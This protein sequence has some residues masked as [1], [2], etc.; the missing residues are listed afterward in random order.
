MSSDQTLERVGT[1]ASERSVKLW[2]TL[3]GAVVN[4]ALA[5]G[6]VTFGFIGHSQALLVDG[7]H[8]LS[9]LVSDFLVVVAAHSSGKE[10]DEDHPYGHARFETAGTVAIGVL[11][12]MLAGG[13]AYDAAQRLIEQER[14]WTPHWIAL[15]AAVVSVAAKEAVYRYTVR[16]GREVGSSL[17]QANA[18]HHRSDALSSL[19]VIGAWFGTVAGYAWVDA[20]AAILVAAMVGAMGWQ[21]AWNAMRELVDTGLEPER[22]RELASVV[23]SV[24]GV[25]ADQGLR[26]RFMAGEVMIDAHIQVDPRLTVSEARRIGEAVRRRLKREC[27]EAGEVVVHIDVDSHS[28]PTGRRPPLR[29]RLLDDLS[30]AWRGQPEAE[31]ATDLTLHYEGDWVDVD[32]ELPADQVPPGELDAIAARLND[33]ASGLPYLRRV[34]CLLASATDARVTRSDGKSIGLR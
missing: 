27:Q 25:E 17:I 16:V 33:A 19:L 4:L 29:Q 13:F 6:K 22:V 28:A 3:V 34:R 18:W 1:K 23:S 10:A 21:F 30:V 32:L 11:L 2:I 14:L 8:S 12:I 9:D 26:S 31:V 24:E 7:I 20:V 5:I 15:V